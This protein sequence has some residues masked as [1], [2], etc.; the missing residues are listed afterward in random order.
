MKNDSKLKKLIEKI[1]E[2]KDA[3]GDD[4]RVSL[5]WIFMGVFIIRSND[6]VS[7]SLTK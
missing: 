1:S 5:I 3:I 6:K 2:K 7:S 4:I